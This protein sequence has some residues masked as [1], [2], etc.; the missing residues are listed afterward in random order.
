MGMG[1]GNK[2]RTGSAIRDRVI[3]G[4]TLFG[5]DVEVMGGVGAVMFPGSCSFL[6][7]VG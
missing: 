7:G 6:G 2:G 5:A 1:L 4:P 3:R